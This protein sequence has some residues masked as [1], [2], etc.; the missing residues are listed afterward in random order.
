MKFMQSVRQWV[1]PKQFRIDSLKTPPDLLSTLERLI[2]NVFVQP[3]PAQDN[4][5]TEIWAEICTNVWRLRLKMLEPGTEK[6]L[7][8]MGRAYRHLES[9]LDAL[10]RAKLQIQD[11]T[12]ELVPEGGGLKLKILTYQPQAGITHQQVQETIK[13]TIYYRGQMIQM[14]EVIVSIP[15]K[16]ESH[17]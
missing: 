11:H 8:E 9:I 1:Y 5:Q 7:E 12:G 6:P 17:T 2:S 13:P 14:G 4:I 15:E 3:P 16:T 10:D